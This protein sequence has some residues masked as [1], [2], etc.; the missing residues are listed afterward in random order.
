ME[1]FP[2]SHNDLQ[3][4]CVF[5]DVCSFSG[6]IR[7]IFACSDVCSGLSLSLSLLADDV[8]QMLGDVCDP[9]GALLRVR[10][11]CCACHRDLDVLRGDEIGLITPKIHPK[12]KQRE[13]VVTARVVLLSFLS[14]QKQKQ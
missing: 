9:P 8:T 1:T 10:L 2:R 13:S 3:P 7:A 14:P 4:S 6:F 11:I 5:S 12:R